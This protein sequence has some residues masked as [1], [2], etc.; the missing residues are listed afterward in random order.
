[1]SRPR[2]L[3]EDRLS[4]EEARLELG[5]NNE[6]AHFSTVFLAVTKGTQLPD[7]SRL[8]LEAIRIGGRWV[9]SRQ[10]IGRYVAVLTE[11]W[12]DPKSGAPI[13]PTL[14]ETDRRLAKANAELSALGI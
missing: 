5:T 9:T 3:D 11:A 1:M 7:K 4:L 6:P 2:I 8:R 12:T 14:K 10:A 13:I